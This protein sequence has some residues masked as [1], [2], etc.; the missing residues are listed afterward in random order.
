M[1]ALIVIAAASIIACTLGII[2]ATSNSTGVTDSNTENKVVSQQIDTE[3]DGATT[4]MMLAA[5]VAAIG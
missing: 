3:Q 4:F 1:K 5:T 2:G